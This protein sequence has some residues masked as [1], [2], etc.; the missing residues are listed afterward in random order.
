MS[1]FDPSQ[2][3]DLNGRVAIVTG[4][5]S[6]LFVPLLIP[7]NT[8]TLPSGLGTTA[9]LLRH[10]ATAYTASRSREKVEAAMILLKEKH[11][12]ADVHFLAC[13]LADLESVKA[14]AGEF[15]QS[16]PSPHVLSL[17]TSRLEK[18]PS[19][20]SWSITLVYVRPFLS[21][22]LLASDADYV[23]PI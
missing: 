9:E 5:H 10:G 8:L 18:N 1:K 11:P 14:A 21:L 2:L 4:G 22:Q 23:H 20:T 3:P 7:V 12:T 6:G 15:I 17:L 16:V 13:D 19:S